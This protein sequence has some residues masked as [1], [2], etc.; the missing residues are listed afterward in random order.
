[1]HL[2]KPSSTV[3]IPIKVRDYK[4]AFPSKMWVQNAKNGHNNNNINNN[5]HKIITITIQKAWSD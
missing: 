1:M 4:V 3:V 5:L 2:F